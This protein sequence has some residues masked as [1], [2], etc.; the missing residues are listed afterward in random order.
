MKNTKVKFNEK[1]ESSPLVSY[2]DDSEK[3]HLWWS[4]LDRYNAAVLS[5][6]EIKTLL[7]R[8]PYMTCREA[9]KLLYQPNNI[10]YNE[11]NF[12]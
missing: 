10:S 2:Y 3:Q 11:C 6:R 8:H 4:C 1:I 9:K 12:E 5:F 7:N